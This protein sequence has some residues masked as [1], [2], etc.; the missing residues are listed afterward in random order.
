MSQSFFMVSEGSTPQKTVVSVISNTRE[1]DFRRSAQAGHGG[2][3]RVRR[4]GCLLQIHGRVRGAIRRCH[5]WLFRPF[6]HRALRSAAGPAVASIAVYLLMAVVLFVRP[7]G[8][9]SGR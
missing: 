4:Q 5:K 6:C 9:F 8:L 3:A 7:Q 2:G 1:K